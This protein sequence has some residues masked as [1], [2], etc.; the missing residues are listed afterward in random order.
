MLQGSASEFAVSDTE[1][2][3]AIVRNTDFS[4]ICNHGAD[5]RRIWGK[6]VA[7]EKVVTSKNLKFGISS[8]GSGSVKGES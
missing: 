3:F 4:M 6:Y 8:F 1:S 7:E 2:A 5:L